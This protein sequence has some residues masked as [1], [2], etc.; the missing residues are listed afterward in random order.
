VKNC[1]S[2]RRVAAH[3]V[4]Q[5]GVTLSKNRPDTATAKPGWGQVRVAVDVDPV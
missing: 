3:T 5:S 4:L 2:S 1:P